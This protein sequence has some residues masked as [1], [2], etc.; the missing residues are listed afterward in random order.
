LAATWDESL[1]PDW[2]YPWL[3]AQA[4]DRK[5]RLVL[6]AAVR[7]ASAECGS[8]LLLRTVETVERFADGAATPRQLNGA[9]YDVTDYLHDPRYRG[10]LPA[11]AALLAAATRPPQT[12]SATSIG[13]NL[14]DLQRLPEG[15]R[16]RLAHFVKDIVANPFRVV[17]CDPGWR[18][19][20]VTGVARGAYDGRAFDRLPILADALQEAGCADETILGHCRG[21]GPHARGCWVVDLILSLS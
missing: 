8:T 1:D 21:G 11:N 14:R 16:A 6:C 20:A 9:D 10:S 19:T 15:E 13:L 18:T 5:L 12:L 4:T 3:G 2:L 17:A 7:A